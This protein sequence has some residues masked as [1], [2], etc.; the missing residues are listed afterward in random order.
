MPAVAAA[1]KRVLHQIA[2]AIQVEPERLTPESKA[3]DFAT[4]D[5]MA[6]V[7]LVFLLQREY[8]IS[9]PVQQATALTSVSAV[10]EAVREAG[11]LA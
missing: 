4:W 9:L 6:L 1:E 5:S 8:D 3:T 11:K 10:L 7:E 2:E